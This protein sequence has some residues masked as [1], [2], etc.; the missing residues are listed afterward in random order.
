M[1]TTFNSRTL[2]LIPTEWRQVLCSADPQLPPEETRSLSFHAKSG[3]PGDWWDDRSL[4]DT[5][6][7]ISIWCDSAMAAKWGEK[8]SPES[9]GRVGGLA[10]RGGREDPQQDPFVSG[11][12]QMPDT[13]F[14][15]LWERVAYRIAAPCEIRLT[16]LGPE[17][18]LD[19]EGWWDVIKQPTLKV[20]RVEVSFSHTVAQ[21]I[22]DDTSDAAR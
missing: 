12:F 21:S 4:F 16:V 6:F 11:G 7:E 8:R 9:E 2:C 14:E 15:D 5:L 22:A 3:W 18:D 20:V 17:P 13:V 1:P 10:F 19:D